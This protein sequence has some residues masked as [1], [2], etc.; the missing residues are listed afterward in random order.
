MRGK[1]AGLVLGCLLSGLAACGSEDVGGRAPPAVQPAPVLTV[2]VDTVSADTGPWPLDPVRGEAQFTEKCQH[3]HGIN[4]TGGYGPSLHSSVTCPPCAEFTMLWRRIDEYMP[5]RNPEACDADCARNIAAWISNGFSVLPSCSVDFRYES[6]AAQRF[7]A[8]I[9]IRNFRGLD[10]PTWRLGFTLPANHGLVATTNAVAA[11]TG[12]QVEIRPLAAAL[13]IPGGATFEIGL[14]GTHG[15]LTV[16]PTGLRL[17]AS[18]CF[19]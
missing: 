13:G 12:D 6:V 11:Q 3:C 8:T 4:A 1:W 15:G 10:V 7:T 14:Q 9:R 17:E 16:V 19:T 18:P 2:P 5:L